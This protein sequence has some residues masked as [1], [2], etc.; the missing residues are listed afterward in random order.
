ME[1]SQGL[2]ERVV[3]ISSMDVYRAWGVVV[4]SE[5]G[6][7]EPLPIT[8]DSPVRS[9]R[10]LY[11]PE[12][13]KMLQSVFAWIDDHY[14][15]VTVEEAILN[16][17]RIP[18]TVLRLPMVYGPGDRLHRFFPLLKRIAD[19]RPFVLL[20]EDFAAWKGPRGYVDNCAHAIALA[21]TVNR[22]AGRVYNVCEEPTLSE[23]EV[24][25][26]IAN[27][28]R[29]SGKFFVLPRERTP[30]HLLLPGNTAQHFDCSSARIRA[31]LGYRETVAID[32]AIRRT[33][34]W[35][36]RNPPAINPQQFNYEAEDA[37]AVHT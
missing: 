15:K 4:G 14:D 8:E 22:A 26:K 7:M 3:A 17:P 5:A 27:E 35:E 9:V 34:E 11:P 19:N 32:D 21:A 29:W 16:D 1:F 6:P 23:L 33:A 25:K 12:A 31:E 10:N 28:M 2:A 24:Q 20:A 37:A 30:Q 18:G 13:I 36:L